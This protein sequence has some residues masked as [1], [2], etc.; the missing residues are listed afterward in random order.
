[1]KTKQED[2]D[3]VEL[4]NDEISEKINENKTTAKEENLQGNS[5]PSIKENTPTIEEEIQ[6]LQ[7]TIQEQKDKYLR[8]MAEFENFKKRTAKERIELIQTAGKD[9]IVSLL[10]VLDDCERAEKQLLEN[11]DIEKQKEGVFL[12]V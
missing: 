6:K 2:N 10:D 4:S 7:I 5:E 11:T 3:N 1:M 12:V 8:L 9:I